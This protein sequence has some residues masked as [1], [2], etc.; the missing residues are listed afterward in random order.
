MS[1]SSSNLPE[2]KTTNRVNPVTGLGKAKNEGTTNVHINDTIHL[3]TSVTCGRVKYISLDLSSSPKLLTNIDSHRQY[4]PYYRLQF[5][6]YP[7]D[8]NIDITPD[9][10]RRESLISHNIHFEC[11]SLNP[12]W[13]LAKTEE[14]ETKGRVKS[15]VCLLFPRPGSMNEVTHVRA[16]G[17]IRPAPSLSR[18]VPAARNLLI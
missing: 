8:T 17:R 1:A 12:T 14:E 9:P 18:S 16:F 3:T 2:R 11:K 10:A 7:D 13:I 4:K 6:I 5:R 15:A